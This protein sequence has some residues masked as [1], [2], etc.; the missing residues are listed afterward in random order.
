MSDEQKNFTLTLPIGERKYQFECPNDSPL[1]EV[2][3]VLGQMRTWCEEKAKEIEEK[4]KESADS[5]P[6]AE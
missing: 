2:Y 1:G 6:I 3:N 4:A 5:E